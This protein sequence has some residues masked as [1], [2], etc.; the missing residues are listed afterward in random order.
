MGFERL[1]VAASL[2]LAMRFVTLVFQPGSDQASQD[3]ASQPD[4][5][6]VNSNHLGDTPQQ[7]PAAPNG[8]PQL[9]PPQLRGG[10]DRFP[11]QTP[12]EAAP[13]IPYNAIASNINSCQTASSA[14][15]TVYAGREIGSGSIVSPDGLVL[16]NNHV[17]RRLRDDSLYITTKNGERYD[18]QVIATDRPYDLALIR[19]QTR[20]PLPMVRFASRGTTDLGQPVCAIGSPFGRPNVLTQG[21]L[22]RVLPNG[23]LQSD[24]LLEPGNS[25]GPLLNVRGEV[26][27]INKGVARGTEERTTNNISY[28]TSALVAQDFLQRNRTAQSSGFDSENRYPPRPDPYS[29]SNRDNSRF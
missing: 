11:V 29:G 8:F 19:L 10:D 26:L 2:L 1:L 28:A 5:T 6:Q 16:T 4:Q 13:N 25:G 17:V 14:V 12:A 27:G 21:K 7:A 15:V 24:V 3:L 22:T 9:Q 18:G 23:D 20:N